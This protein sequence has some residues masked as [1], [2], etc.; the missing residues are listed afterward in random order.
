MKYLRQSIS[1]TGFNTPTFKRVSENIHAIQEFFQR[2]IGKD[3]LQELT[4]I[5]DFEDA[6]S[7]DMGNRYFT[8]HRGALPGSMAIP[9][10][11]DV[12]PH[13][14]LFKAGGSTLF[15][16]EDNIVGYYTKVLDQTGGYK[17]VFSSILQLLPLHSLISSSSRFVKTKPINFRPGDIVEV[18]VSFALLP[19]REKKYKL[20]LILRSLTILDATFSQACSSPPRSG[21]LH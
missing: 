21:I 13:S 5:G 6:L 20:S 18:Q 4:V 15:H 1:L 9:F 14:Y 10:S 12:D 8:P 7:I 2:F 3:S 17:S 11:S 19:L 16:S